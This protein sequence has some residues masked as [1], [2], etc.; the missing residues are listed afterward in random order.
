MQVTP[1]DVLDY[2]NGRTV[3]FLTADDIAE[4][5]D[6][7]DQTARN[8]LSILVKEDKLSSVSLGVGK[9]KLYFRPDYEAA[10]RAIDT[11]RKHFDIEAVDC[12]DL[13]IF[14]DE[15]YCI[16][17]KESG[18]A[19]VVCPR[20]VPFHVGWLDRQTDSYNVFVVNKYVDWIDELPDEIRNQVGIA[21]KYDSATVVDN[22]L[23]V[24]M[25]ERAEA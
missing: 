5:F 17:P 19:W 22:T 11:L 13:A 1:A 23:E 12:E 14:A 15:P 6:C 16:L 2:L 20:F 24:T 9:P 3:P 4:R 21:A 8:K 10:S 7:S 18:E 25:D